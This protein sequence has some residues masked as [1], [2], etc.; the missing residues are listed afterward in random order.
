MLEA[1]LLRFISASRGG[2]I[3][4]L[5][6]AVAISHLK[7]D[8]TVCV[9]IYEAAAKITQVGAGITLWPRGWE[10]LKDLGL[11]DDLAA[12]VN[13]GQELPSRKKRGVYSILSP[14]IARRRI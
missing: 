7:V 1:H 6:L 2:G 11:E 8:E 4:G 5:A 14:Y 13:P 10:I 12:Y 9:D 3:G